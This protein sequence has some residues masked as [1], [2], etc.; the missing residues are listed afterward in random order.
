MSLSS[1]FLRPSPLTDVDTQ[2]FRVLYAA[3]ERNYEAAVRRNVER[4]LVVGRASEMVKHLKDEVT[5]TAPAVGNS[6]PS[7][8]A[9]A[10]RS[11]A[12]QQPVPV[13]IRQPDPTAFQIIQ[14]IV[15]PLLQPLATTGIVIIFV[16]FFLLQREDLRDRF[17]RL[18]GSSDLQ[19][20]T[21]ALDEAG[22]RV[23]RYLLVQAAINASFGLPKLINVAP[24]VA[25]RAARV[26]SCCTF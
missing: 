5:K 23:S 2:K 11:D 17:I 3:F 25:I 18:A 15:G 16:I 19:R 26:P 14:T 22:H 24:F 12:Q 1:L 13:E 20:T 10:P 6:A 8:R 7:S 4:T 21:Q 9:S